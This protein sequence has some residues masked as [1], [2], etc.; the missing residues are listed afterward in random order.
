VISAQG[1]LTLVQHTETRG[2]FPRSFA[3]LGQGARSWLVA[4]NQNSD[5]VAMWRRSEESGRLTE[6]GEPLKICEGCGPTFIGIAKPAPSL[7]NST[8]VN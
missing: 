1:E 7:G 2:A 6:V 8:V 4:A 3:L 5:T